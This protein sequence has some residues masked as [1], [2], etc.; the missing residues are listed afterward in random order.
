MRN[1][2]RSLSGDALVQGLWIGDSL[3]KV[4]CACMR[5]YL[6]FGHEFHL[7]AYKQY[8]NLP[9]GVKW[10][11]A[12][13]IISESEIFT[14]QKGPGKGSY[15]AFANL[16]RY[17]LLSERGGWWTDM[18]FICLAPLPVVE[19][20]F[21]AA[22]W[23]VTPSPLMGALRTRLT[24]LESKGWNLNGVKRLLY[25]EVPCN[26]LIF[27]PQ[28][29][30][31]MQAALKIASEAVTENLNWG[32]TGPLLIA[33]LI[34]EY[35]HPEDIVI[36]RPSEFL[37]MAGRQIPC[38]FESGGRFNLRGAKTIHLYNEL[39]RRSGYDKDAD[40]RNDTLISRLLS[41]HSVQ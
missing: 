10:M 18:D 1:K 20:L 4:E 16:F 14:Y 9:T 6:S 17:K 21:V 23:K 31:L 36:G 33:R 22:E 27:S 24:W 13:S 5:S 29:F 15:G 37:P 30:P 25:D 39:W 38:L 11:D 26:G 8:E 3:S 40:F 12:N 35:Q 7:Y 28:G 34:A 41:N 32:E 2:V 19:G